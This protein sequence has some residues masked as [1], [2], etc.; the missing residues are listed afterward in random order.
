MAI[1]ASKTRLGHEVSDLP[2]KDMN[3]SEVWNGSTRRVPTPTNGSVSARD[4][5]IP[6]KGVAPVL[7]V[8]LG[9][10]RRS[11]F[12]Y[13]VYYVKYHM[14]AGASLFTSSAPH[15]VLRDRLQ[16]RLVFANRPAKSDLRF[17]VSRARGVDEPR[18]IFTNVS[19]FAQEH[20]HHMDA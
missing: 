17:R 7:G 6:R 5:A 2:K 1:H 8:P 20:R 18:H 13:N 3:V 14:A 15:A 10:Q 19:T 11:A 4:G 12:A 16:H 9:P